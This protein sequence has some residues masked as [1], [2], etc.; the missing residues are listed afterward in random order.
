[1]DVT[2][3]V[4]YAIVVFMKRL[5]PF[6]LIVAL[7]V[8]SVGSFI[9]SSTTLSFRFPSLQVYADEV[10]D[11]QREIDELE[12]LKK[13]S[14]DATK[15]L[16]EQVKD[17]DTRIRN[18]QNGITQAKKQ[19]ELL[20]Q[21][22]DKRE[23]DLEKQYQLLSARVAEQYK[24][25]RMFSPLLLILSTSDAAHITKDLAYRGSVKAQ[26]NKLIQNISGDISK[27]EQD[28][29]KLEQ[30]QV[31]LAQLQI[32]LDSQANFFKAEIA[33][34]KTYQQELGGKIAALSA[35]QQAVIAARSG[36]ETTNANNVPSSGDFD[37]TLEGFRQNAPSGSFGIFSF[38]A[39]T[40]RKGMSQ[41]GAK[42]RAE[43]NQSANQIVKAYY[44]KDPVSKET[45]GTISVQGHGNLNFEDKYLMG[46]A[47]MPSSWPKEA[48][49]AQAIAARTYAYRYK[50]DGQTICTTEACQVFSMDKANNPPAAWR[51]A[52]QE[53][54]GKVLEDVV[55][56]YSSTTGGYLSTMG[57]DTTNG[58]GSGDW[59]GK[60]WE[61]KGGSPW[62]Y[63]AWYRE[64]YS[65]TASS[66]GRKP[67]MTQE[68][69]ADILNAYLVLRDPRG[70][71]TGRILPVTIRE[72][73]VGGQSGNPYSMS[74]LR[75]YVDNPVTSISGRPSVQ[76]NDSGQTTTITF[77]TNRGSI[78]ISGSDF[79]EAFNTRAPGYLRIPQ[80]GFTFINIEKK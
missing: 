31:T 80:S 75:G 16:E 48:L 6:F 21:D 47:E 60:A 66:C 68:E 3:H 71:D 77:Q 64:G 5:L 17:L 67:W 50:R 15:P 32:K 39:Y 4:I 18:A 55:T 9:H 12:K 72:C 38:G 49:K 23:K 27:L 46:I 41:Y 19:S 58:S 43:D 35:Q 45:G 10:E 69:M 36:S 62:F 53:T 30:D 1:M 44:G 57:W 33:K 8:W 70:A 20:S 7:G 14:E 28:K 73:G 63:K 42:G 59:T 29:K 61:V 51:E 54:R 22:I 26:D 11:L 79:K 13:M 56:F 2:R 24:K 78:T 37:S 52:V 25:G 34:A 74:E 40:H 76:H 65:N